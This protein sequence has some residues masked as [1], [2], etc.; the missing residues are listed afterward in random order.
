[1][2][3]SQEREV[4]QNRQSRVRPIRREQVLWAGGIVA[5][6]LLVSILIGYLYDITLWNWIKV[7]ALPITVGAAVPLL[8]KLQKDRELDIEAKRKD[9]ELAIQEQY[10]QDAA[11]QAYLDQMAQLMLLDEAD[12][13]KPKPLRKSEDGDEVRILARTR[14]LT[15]LRRLDSGRK[16]SVLDFLYEARLIQKPQPIIQLGSPDQEYNVADLSGAELR[17]AVLRNAALSG[18]HNGA[19]LS[20]AELRDAD[21]SLADLSNV[22][23]RDANLSGADLQNANLSGANLFNANL[24]G[25]YLPEA[26][27]EYAELRYANVEGAREVNA[28]QLEEQSSSLEGATMPNG[29]KY[30][31]WLKSKGRGEDGE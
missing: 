23:L 28:E 1:M 3:R 7:L 31:D 21:L 19:N 30:E 16:R 25:A 6:V 14:T 10:T 5:A 24:V 17:G 15:V 2:R 26:T 18:T 27:L 4:D 13:A 29:Q 12:E 9:R 8:N 11:L 22:T 20:R